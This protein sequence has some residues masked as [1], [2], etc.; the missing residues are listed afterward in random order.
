MAVPCS[1]RSFILAP[2]PEGV[3]LSEHYLVQLLGI[4][5][6]SKLQL[7]FIKVTILYFLQ[8]VFGQYPTRIV[9]CE[10][11]LPLAVALRA[12]E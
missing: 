9:Y 1:W 6:L 8:P 2:R 11:H 10:L 7:S 5:T 3:N 12:G 4:S